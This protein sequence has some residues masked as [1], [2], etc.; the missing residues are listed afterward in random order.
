M[1]GILLDAISRCKNENELSQ[2]CDIAKST[3][4]INKDVE[5]SIN[6]SKTNTGDRYPIIVKFKRG[7]FEYG[8]DDLRLI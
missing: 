4:V 8:A 5:K 6:D 3:R 1:S 2:I 7:T